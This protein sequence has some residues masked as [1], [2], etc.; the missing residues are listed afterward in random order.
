MR[1]PVHWRYRTTV[2][3]LCM[4]VYF[5]SRAGQVAL[6]TLALDIVATL[7]IT[8]S[9][10][11]L[12]FTGLSLMSALAQLPS[13]ALSDQY[14]ERV[15]IMSAI[16]LTGISVLLLA[17]APTFLVFLPLM[18]L[19]G[20]GSG[21]Y[22]SPSTALL[23][24]L[25]NR[26]GRAIGTYRISGQLAGVF[27]PIVVGVVSFYYGWRVALFAMGLLL[28]PA[29]GGVLVLMKPTPP[30]NPTT[31]LRTHASPRRIV[32][33]VSRP[34]IAGATILAG[35]VQFV[36]VASFTFLPA[37]LQQ[38]HG[39]SAAQAGGLFTLYFTVVAAIHPVSGWLSDHF[40]RDAVTGITLLTG[41]FGFSLLT[42]QAMF[43]G[44]VTAVILAGVSMTWAAP[45]QSLLMDNLG[46]TDRGVGFGLVRTIYLLVGALGSYVI[47]ILIT[48]VGWAFAFSTLAG[49]LALCLTGIAVSKFAYVFN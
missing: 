9:L 20:V 27:A 45:V 31:S 32:T 42:R 25:Y 13:G 49:L 35:I 16:I 19:V 48:E 47:G 21:L 33:I 24:R 1:L 36:E 4:A 17:L 18:V 2:L 44:L 26:I 34:G 39:L 3:G 28:V 30:N 8:M 5:G 22:Y 38:Y 46:K 6:S 23:D 12:S 14:G 41:F 7:G 11:G 15:L 37:L 29:F 43:P 10:F 40:G